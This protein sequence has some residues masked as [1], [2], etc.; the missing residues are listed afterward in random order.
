MSLSKYA[1]EAVKNVEEHLSKM[2]MDMTLNRNAH[3]P[4]LT[5]Y[6]PELDVSS[7]LSPSDANYYQSQVRILRWMVELGCVDIITEV[8]TLAS[9][10]AMPCQGHLDA[11]Y[12]IFGYL[13]CKHNSW[14]VFDPSY[15]LIDMLSFKE[16]DWKNYYGNVSEAIPPNAPKEVGKDVDLHLFVDLSHADDQSTRRSRSGFFIF[17]NMAPIVW[18]SKKQAHN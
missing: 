17:M 6:I 1:Q 15:P 7:V 13:K 10:L 4:F 18:L 14:L 8:S 2:K 9:H 5:G 16:C 12:H 3:V 11:V